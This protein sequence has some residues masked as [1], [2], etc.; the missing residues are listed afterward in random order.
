MPTTP[1]SSWPP[2]DQERGGSRSGVWAVRILVL[3][4]LLIVG[5]FAALLGLVYSEARSASSEPVDAIVVLGAAQFD[6]VPSRVFRARLDTA[7][8]LYRQG[9]SDTVV[10]TGGRMPGDRFT[11]AEAGQAYLIEQGVPESNIVL[12]HL[13]TNTSESMDAVA[14]LLEARGASSVMLVSD[15]FHLYRARM[16]ADDVGL[17][18]RT[19]AAAGSPIRP[20]SMTEFRYAVREALAIAAYQVGMAD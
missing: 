17:E 9:M 19:H 5:A 14:R 16:L 3:L 10:V 18:A 6:G 15:G 1:D 4:I 2:P 8:D 11:E 20:G 7:A 13:A 12:E